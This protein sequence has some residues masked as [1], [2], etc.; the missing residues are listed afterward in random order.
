MT[1]EA[2]GVG[3]VSADSWRTPIENER[4]RLT[5]VEVSH[6]IN[7]SRISLIVGL[8]FLH[9]GRYPNAPISPFSGIDSSGH[10]LA[11]FVNSF[12]LFFFFSAVPLLSMVSGWLFFSFESDPALEL[13]KRIRKRF[14]SLYVP[15]VIWN[16]AYLLLMWSLFKANS[17]N[18]VLNDLNI[19]F[20]SAQWKQYINAVFAVTQYPIGFQF[21]FVRD[22][23]VTVLVSPL[24]WMVLKRAPL[25]GAAVLAVVWLSDLNVPIF[26]RTDVLFFFYIGGVLRLRKVPLDIDPKVTTGLLVAYFLLVAVRALTP[27]I[28]DDDTAVVEVATKALR[29]VG[30]AACWGLFQSIAFSSIGR[31]VSRYNGFAFFLYAAHFPLIA[32]LKITLWSLV[33]AQTELWMVIHYLVTV[34][35]TVFVG[36]GLG[37]ALARFA[38]R[39]FALMNGGRPG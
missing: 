26:F 4:R 39:Q 27:Y 21:W 24:L 1:A 18:P 37:V 15:F 12:V 25:Y 3:A 9:Y 20:A 16:A 36:V 2:P 22:L 7:F 8:V 10:Q 19:D 35:V 33:P 29:L 14:G 30:V 23:F 32:A 13:A 28:A 11:T 6:L 5:T 34:L 38:P 17:G 31:A